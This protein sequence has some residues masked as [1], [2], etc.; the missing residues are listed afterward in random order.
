MHRNKLWLLSFGSDSD[1]QVHQAPVPP[2]GQIWKGASEHVSGP[3]T[4]KYNQYVTSSTQPQSRDDLSPPG[5]G[6]P[7]PGIGGSAPACDSRGVVQWVVGVVG[8]CAVREVVVHAGGA[9]SGG[10]LADTPRHATG[11]Q[12]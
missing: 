12:K 5:S 9:T 11:L 8:G 2:W 6:A 10:T 1:A 3:D 4:S 7:G